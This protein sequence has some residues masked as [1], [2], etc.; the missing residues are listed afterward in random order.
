MTKRDP[1]TNNRAL[2]ILLG[3]C[4][5]LYG[6]TNPG[7]VRS[8]DGEVI[9]RTAAALASGGEFGV[10]ERL[11][12]W[13]EFGFAEGADG[14][15]YTFY[16]PG[17][18]L[19]CAPMIWIARLLNRTGWYEGEGRT[20][21]LSHYVDDGIR[22]TING[23]PPQELL[24]HAERIIVSFL[25]IPITVLGVALFWLL[26]RRLGIPPVAALVTCF[27]YAFGSMTWP[28]AN[29]FFKEPLAL[30]FILGSLLLMLGKA[31]KHRGRA[32]GWLPG[33][34]LS[35]LLMGL[36]VATHEMSALFVPFFVAFGFLSH[37]RGFRSWKGAVKPTVA[38]A[39]G[40]LVILLLLLWHNQTRFGGLLD[41]GRSAVTINP[42]SPP[43][44]ASYWTGLFGLLLGAGKG[45]LI[46]S[47]LVVAG[48]LFWRRFAAEYRLLAGVLAAM[49]LVR[50][51]VVAAYGA[52]HGGFCLGP[53][54]L[55]MVVP[56][57]FIPLA[58]AIRDWLA[59][60]QLKQ[61]R[62][63]AVAGFLCVSQQ[64]YFCVGE[65]FT[66]F[67]LIKAHNV[68]RGLDVMT[69]NTIY[70]NW[71]ISPLLNLLRYRRGPWVFADVAASNWM[72]WLVLS[73]L[74]GAV[75]YL[76]YVWV[77]NRRE[78]AAAP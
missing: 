40:G 44:T 18:S 17:Q 41:T 1:I 43:W 72:L 54:Y 10:E 59:T 53:R 67:Q 47:P 57:L 5:A 21:P 55:L 24:P 14:K 31:G 52:W 61:L 62:V 46:Y 26:L 71:P 50:F 38:L 9:Y 33:L 11:E 45:L 13:P 8:A 27:L 65:V 16:G 68:I 28:Y 32:S 39:G 75:T 22:R 78:G 4:L 2:G 29:T 35:G 58:F 15:L 37:G 51:L 56:F 42:F 6:L 23:N 60:R 3:V 36:A 66:Y 12:D 34:A 76:G 69:D 48:V 70:F 49:I 20:I 30:V 74:M 19:V 63:L 7:G 25:Y 77:L 73:A 64:V